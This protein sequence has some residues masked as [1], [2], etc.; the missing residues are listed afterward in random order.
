MTVPCVLCAAWGKSDLYYVAR[1]A[2][3]SDAESICVDPDEISDCRWMDV[4]EFMRTQDHPLITAVLRHAYG[5]E[6]PESI[7]TAGGLSPLVEMMEAPVQ[8]PGREPYP[9]YF[10]SKGE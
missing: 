5:L 6:A 8:W 10:A 2:P 4:D 9:T 3:A 7:G 1:L